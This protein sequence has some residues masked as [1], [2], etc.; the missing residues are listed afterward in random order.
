MR[1]LTSNIWGTHENDD[2]LNPSE[3]R[4]IGKH[5]QSLRDDASLSYRIS[6]VD[7]SPIRASISAT[8][9]LMGYLAQGLDLT[10]GEGI[11]RIYHTIDDAFSDL[12]MMTS[13]RRK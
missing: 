13:Q 12:R 3:P 4:S 6:R 5:F 11:R 8:G 9:A 1:Y 2:P 10:V 7:H